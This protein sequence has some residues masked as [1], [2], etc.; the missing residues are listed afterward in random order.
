[1]SLVNFRR[2]PAYTNL[3]AVK[4]NH[5]IPDHVAEFFSDISLQVMEEFGW[6]TPKLLNEYSCALED[7]LLELQKENT[8]LKGRVALAEMRIEGLRAQASKGKKKKNKKNKK[9]KM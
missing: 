7:S 5:F 4:G 3:R 6:E 9:N 2:S 1:M 8:K